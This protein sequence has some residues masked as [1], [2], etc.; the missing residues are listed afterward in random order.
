MGKKR[1]RKLHSFLHLPLTIWEEQ[2]LLAISCASSREG[3]IDH[4][5]TL[6]S[7]WKP[8]FIFKHF[9]NRSWNNLLRSELDPA[10]TSDGTI[11][12]KAGTASQRHFEINLIEVT[13]QVLGA[14]W[15]QTPQ[16]VSSH[17]SSAQS[18]GS[19]SR[20]WSS[21]SQSTVTINCEQQKPSQQPGDEKNLRSVR[22]EEML[23]EK[24]KIAL[25]YIISSQKA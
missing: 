8:Q 14:F 6:D 23:K 11:T 4:P 20:L 25:G 19:V 13:S 24:H 17:F 2:N 21:C 7:G 5:L 3:C 9:N 15:R 18:T 22:H 1:D 12:H 16:A 10:C